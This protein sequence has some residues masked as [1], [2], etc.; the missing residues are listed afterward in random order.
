M[1]LAIEILITIV[2]LALLTL[3]IA[4]ATA[5]LWVIAMLSAAIVY[6][7]LS[8][9][10][11][12]RR[13]YFL[14]A[15]APHS[16]LFAVALGIPLSRVVGLLDEFL[17]AV[18]L[19]LALLY[20]VGYLIHRGI[21]P[22]TATSIFIAF[23]ASGSVLALYYVLTTYS[24]E[25]NVWAIIVGDPLLISWKEAMYSIVIAILILCGIIVSY[26]ENICLGVDRDF[27]KLAGVNTKIYDVILFTFLAVATVA[28]IRY[29]GFVLEHILI[30]LPASIAMNATDSACK[31]LTLS[32]SISIVASLI[33]LYAAVQFNIAPAGAVGL[34]MM[35]IYMLSI[36]I[37]RMRRHG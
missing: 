7:V 36:V 21:D 37:S 31:S 5:W 11:A 18:V 30:L 26:R 28:L 34:V 16:A 35:I 15:S 4:S 10:V 12:A 29:I 25:Y 23:T 9:V 3:V 19:G 2:A 27:V 1:R 32:V 13:L 14:A 20:T 24:I 33:G 6:G 8:P 22:D 17:W